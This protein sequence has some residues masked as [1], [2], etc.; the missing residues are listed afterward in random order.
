M[1]EKK[2]ENLIFGCI[3]SVVCKGGGGDGQNFTYWKSQTQVCNFVKFFCIILE[4]L[5]NGWMRFVYV[6]K[7]ECT[8]Y[9]IGSFKA[10]CC[11]KFII[12]RLTQFS[13]DSYWDFRIW[14][15]IELC[16]IINLQL[17]LNIEEAC[18]SSRN[19]NMCSDVEK[20]HY[21]VDYG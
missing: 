7:S 3:S 15:L 16:K 12:W 10:M 5:R 13:M 18:V 17:W 21:S 19:G 6:T 20:I 14:A 9:A 4:L 2:P 8:G 1:R 11:T